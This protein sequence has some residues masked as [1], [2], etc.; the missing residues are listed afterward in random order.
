MA[1]FT[2]LR[3]RHRW[4][5]TNVD[6]FAD[7][8]LRGAEL[9]RFE[10]HLASCRACAAAVREARGMKSLLRAL[11]ELP[12]TRS[13]AITESMLRTPAPVRQPAAR[14]WTGPIRAVQGMGAAALALFAVLVVADLGGAGAGSIAS[15]DGDFDAVPANEDVSTTGAADIGAPQGGDDDAGAGDPEIA[16]PEATPGGGNVE[17]AGVDPPPPLP[18]RTGGGL[19]TD[20]RGPPDGDD[21]SRVDR[22]HDAGDAETALA[23]FAAEDGGG[24]DW[25]RV[26]QVFS[27]GLAL[28][29]AAAYVGMRRR[30][31]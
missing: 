21:A 23:Q 17:G 9:T 29:A 18:D 15:P 14:G 5:E 12:V 16:V 31:A 3:G 30:T 8:E 1:F 28:L 19:V 25:L 24:A 10:T 26:G 20:D 27:A 11:P 2:V 6:A 22:A 7:G 4:F 13:F